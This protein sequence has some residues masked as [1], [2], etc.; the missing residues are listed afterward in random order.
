M[1]RLLLIS[2]L[3]AACSSNHGDSAATSG[4]GSATPTAPELAVTIAGKPATIAQAYIQAL[5]YDGGYTVYLTSGTSS[6]QELRDG[7]YNRGKDDQ[8]VLFSVGQRLAKD[9][10][11]GGQIVDVARM[12]KHVTI[13]PG[14]KLTVPR[15]PAAGVKLE[16]PVELDADVAGEGTIALHGVISAEGCGTQPFP[17]D[18]VPKAPHASTATLQIAGTRVPFVGARYDAKADQLELS[19]SPLVCGPSTALAN[20]I[21]TVAH[22]RWTLHGEWFGGAT[23]SNTSGADANGQEETRGMSAKLGAPGASADGPTVP[24]E[25]SGAGTIGGTPVTVAGTI[26]ALACP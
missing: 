9:G 15:A 14:S 24:V 18:V 25:L 1:R 19:S 20:V 6:C 13:A 22:L 10:A 17:A 4:S 23:P 11:H 3:A 8:T 21:L 7:L 16:L 5:P 2:C 12:G 26:E